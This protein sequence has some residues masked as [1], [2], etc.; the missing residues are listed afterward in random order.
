MIMNGRNI[1]GR[2]IGTYFV[3]ALSLLGAVCA[4]VHSAR[5]QY[6]S[7]GQIKKDGTAIL[8]EDYADVPPSNP[9]KDG[10][11]PAKIDPTEQIARVNALRSEP[12]DVPTSATRFFVA[13]NNGIL[14]LMDKKT[15]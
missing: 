13:D 4:A 11:Y 12:S 14:Y 7:S 3:F 9:S 2:G 10:P 15:K 5:A 1:S 8:I 6:P